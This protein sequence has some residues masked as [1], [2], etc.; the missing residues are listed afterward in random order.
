MSLTCFLSNQHSIVGIADRRKYHM[1]PDK[2]MRS[3]SD[4]G[5]KLF[6]ASDNF[7][8]SKIGESTNLINGFIS[9]VIEEKF[10]FMQTVEVL[11]KFYDTFRE[12]L[13]QHICCING[14]GM[15]DGVSHLFASSTI[16]FKIRIYKGH[17]MAMLSGPPDYDPAEWLNPVFESGNHDL[18]SL[19]EMA[20]NLIKHAS[21]ISKFVSPGYD[22][23]CLGGEDK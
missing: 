8:I 17:D 20:K 15:V 16:G 10:D 5:S 21:T 11:Q 3:F 1:N 23:F 4:D 7:I 14:G 9:K 22:L 18:S 13:K 6:K 19:M 12:Q 2:T